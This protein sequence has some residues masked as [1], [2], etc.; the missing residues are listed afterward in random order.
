MPVIISPLG[1]SEDV[2]DNAEEKSR[3]PEY[4]ATEMIKN[5]HKEIFTRKRTKYQ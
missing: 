2:L 3:V 5:N 4:R 1:R